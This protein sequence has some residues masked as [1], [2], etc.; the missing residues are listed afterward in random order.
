MSSVTERKSAR[1]EKTAHL[2]D[3]LLN[4]MPINKNQQAAY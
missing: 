3:G 4:S 1:K 2:S